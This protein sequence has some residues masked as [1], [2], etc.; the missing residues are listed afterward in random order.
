METNAWFQLDEREIES[1]VSK[2]FDE[3]KA[4]QRDPWHRG[5]RAW[6]KMQEQKKQTLRKEVIREMNELK[7]LQYVTILS[8]KK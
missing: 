8:Y 2:R 7:I 4:K 6:P 3:W 1:E 5:R